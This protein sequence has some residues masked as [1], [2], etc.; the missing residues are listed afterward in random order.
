MGG[1]CGT[2]GK[3]KKPEIT[4]KPW[5]TCPKR[6]DN[7]KASL[8]YDECDGADWIHFPPDRENW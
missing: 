8:K 7:I 4:I 6:E 1:A 2:N 5:R 3:E